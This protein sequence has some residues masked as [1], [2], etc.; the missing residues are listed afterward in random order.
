MPGSMRAIARIHRLGL[1]ITDMPD[2][3]AAPVAQI[4]AA[5]KR[6][7]HC[8]RTG[9]MNDNELLVVRAEG[10][11]PLIEQNLGPAPV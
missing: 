6:D 11:Y 7:I 9:A 5:N 10:K 3:V 4:D 8:R 1:G 2:I